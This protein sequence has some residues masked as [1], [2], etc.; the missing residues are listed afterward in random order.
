MSERSL[1]VLPDESAKPILDAINAAKKSL[2]VKMFVFS[3]PAL[4]QA[5]VAAHERGVKVRVMLNAA[6]RSGEDDNKTVRKALDKAGIAQKDSSPDFGITHEKSMV[7]DEALAFV[8]SLNWA[9]KNLTE[10]RDYAITTTHPHAVTEI[11]ECFEAD[12]HRKKFKPGLSAHLIWCPANGRERIAQFIDEARHTLFVQNERYQDTVIIE[13]LVRAR[14]RGVKIHLMAR[15][16]HSLK[17]DKIIEGV[18]GLRIMDDVGIKIHK[19]KHLK[20]HGKMLLAD[21]ARAIVGSINLAPGSFDDRRELAIELN[22]DDIVDRL[23]KIA[24]HD[25]KHSHPLD[26]TDEGLFTDLEEKGDGGA[27]KLVLRMDHEHAKKHAKK[28]AK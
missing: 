22:D 3:D 13:R 9:T 21:G 4:L 28:H 8:K 16:P 6:R 12:W 23:H 15:P 17:K 25:W 24:K 27:E 14:E 7:V 18:G 2:H 11:I 10:T 1:I 20:L 19:L 26:L 5:V